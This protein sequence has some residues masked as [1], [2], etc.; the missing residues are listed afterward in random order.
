M[1]QI[2][3]KPLSASGTWT[4]INPSLRG[5]YTRDLD[6]FFLDVIERR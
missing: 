4:A 2:G 3:I 5:V 6:G 1:N